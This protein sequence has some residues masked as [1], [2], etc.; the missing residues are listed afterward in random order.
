MLVQWF[1]KLIKGWQI[2]PLQTYLYLSNV[3]GSTRTLRVFYIFLN[4]ERNNG[5]F[6]S[7]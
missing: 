2:I 1:T 7:N 6:T 4:E 5:F 3:V